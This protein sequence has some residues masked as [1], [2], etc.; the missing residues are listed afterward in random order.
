MADGQYRPMFENDTGLGTPQVVAIVASVVWLLV[1][2]LVTWLLPAAP[3]G[4]AGLQVL[5][6]VMAGVL[7][8]ALIWVVAM[9]VRSVGVMRAESDRLHGAIDALRVAYVNDHKDSVKSLTVAAKLEEI[10]Q[11]ARKT[12]TALTTFTT[13]RDIAAKP[14]LAITSI[15]HAVAEEQ[16]GLGLDPRPEDDT[17]P[18]DRADFI[19]ALHFPENET[20][21]PGFAAL[22]R[23]LKDRTARQL[24]QAAQDVLTLLSEDGIYMDD[25][26]PDRARTELW[27]RFAQGERGRTMAGLGG[28][29]DRSS[30]ALSAGR[31]R[32]DTI[33][34]DAAHHF[35]RLF[36]KTLV[37]FEPDATDA[38][39]AAFADTRTARAFMLL[40]RVTGAFD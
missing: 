3:D 16:P 33:F 32:E 22:R 31:M 20:D 35:L 14:R 34:R 9:A 15:R 27:R 26:T 7:P 38:E 36:D 12:E 13:S 8:V 28:I 6:V 21:M 30:L 23:A 18:L 5:V 1:V 10:A 4:A 17:P 29:R 11:T 25:L 24:V 2:G 39:M 40:G 19:R 37:K